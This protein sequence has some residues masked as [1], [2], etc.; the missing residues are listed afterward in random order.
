[1]N[2]FLHIIYAITCLLFLSVQM[3]CV[4]EDKGEGQGILKL[5]VGIN[6]GDVVVDTKSGTTIQLDSCKV[7]IKNRNGD[8]IR[9]Y[10]NA[11]T[12]PT[13]EWL[14][15]GNYTVEASL[16]T[17]KKAEFDHPCYAGKT[18]VDIVA[19][20]SV[21]KEVVCK[22]S[23]SKVSLVYEKGITS[24]FKDY[25]TVVAMDA[26]NLEFKKDSIKIG[27]YYNST[28]EKQNLICTVTATP[29]SGS[30]V[31]KEFT[32]E[33]IQPCTHYIIHADYNM[34]L[35]EGGFKFEIEIN[36]ELIEDKDDNVVIPIT[37]Y[38][39][40]DCA[41]LI[42]MDQT[43][44]AK[45][46]F[47]LKVVGYP[48]LSNILL[49]GTF[50]NTLNLPS[51]IDLL[52]L[53]ASAKTELENKGF[54]LGEVETD[55]TDKFKHEMRIIQ[56]P[57]PLTNLIS[58]KLNIKVIDSKRQSKDLNDIEI[59][60][61]NLNVMTSNV[62]VY[63]VWATTAVLRGLLK[64]GKQ[65]EN[66]SFQYKKEN[67]EIWIDV[68]STNIIEDGENY[69]TKIKGLNPGVTYQYRIGENGSYAAY[70][71]FTTEAAY[72]VPNLGFEDWC[73]GTFS[74][75][76]LGKKDVLYPY[77]ENGTQYWDSGNAG[78]A[79]GL[80][81]PTNKETSV[82]VK[83]IAAKLTS[84]VAV[85]NFAAGNIYTGKFR[86]VS[87]SPTGAKLDF[88]IEYAERPSKLTGYYKYNPQTI[89]YVSSSFNHLKGK[90]DTCAIYIA[91][92][93]W[94]EPFHVNTAAG[95]FPQFDTD[96]H[97]IAYG[98]LSNE[99][100]GVAEM[101]GYKQFT[102]NL[103]YRSLKKK[104]TKLLIVASASK[105]GDYFTGGE[106]SELLIDEFKLIFDED[107]QVDE[108][109]IKP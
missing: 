27:Y 108:K 48:E 94:D 15:A 54:I 98:A 92:T 34:E 69:S 66:V 81:T 67:E 77:K 74:I 78:A 51:S 37:K 41:K 83:G 73:M 87:L 30:V 1:M 93:D 46:R 12:M 26:S 28:E 35:A 109:Y 97:I 104:P 9:Q 2:N 96:P 68:A 32:I 50:L 75:P 42:M 21:S 85:G 60:V 82:V 25:S 76:I 57:V 105:Y 91:L 38:P 107:I 99:E 18:E 79:A 20:K 63:D 62:D 88:G 65:A 5:Q 40:I 56:I 39:F 33:N 55:P 3:A 58:E 13:E 6:E 36:D 4:P 49:S 59:I 70:K 53:E 64:E 100:A 29:N 72:Q 45:E 89:N 47:T 52:N 11:V 14:L 86:D 71:T 102:I 8:I 95:Q 24:N 61:T 17:T 22:L 7:L 101:N 10:E 31:K 80:K 90:I 106:K 43:L 84:E 103:K 23:Q 16:G 19:N 44:G